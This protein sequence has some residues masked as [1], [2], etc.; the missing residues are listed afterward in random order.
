MARRPS[1][2]PSLYQQQ[3]ANKRALEFMSSD[4]VLPPAL[5]EGWAEAPKKRAA[6][7]DLEGPVVKAISELLAVHPHIIVAWRMNSGMASY[8]AKSGKYAPVF[9]HKWLKPSGGMRMPDFLGLAF[10]GVLGTPSYRVVPFACE[11]KAPGWTHP[12]DKRESEQA[13]FID[14][15]RHYGGI[16]IFATSVEQ[17]AEALK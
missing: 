1:F 4:G 8:E 17:V 7:R 9:F 14:M 10:D 16:G 2:K 6:P 15:I 11:A 12:R 3:Q 13:A 5:R